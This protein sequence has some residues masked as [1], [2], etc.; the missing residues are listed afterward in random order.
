MYSSI[1][2]FSMTRATI[3]MQLPHGKVISIRCHQN[4]E[5]SHLGSILLSRFGS[6]SLIN[7]II[8]GDIYSLHTHSQQEVLPFIRGTYPA[9]LYADED[10]FEKDGAV[11]T[12]NYLR[13]KDGLWYVSTAGSS[14]APFTQIPQHC[15]TDQ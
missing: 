6:S 11:E 13:R 4:G 5:P 14:F 2:S 15:N 1:F 10:S 7:L 9:V 12:Y 8:G 3:A